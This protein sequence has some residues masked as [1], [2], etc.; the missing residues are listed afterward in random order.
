[1]AS[2]E[3]FLSSMH[4]FAEKAGISD[5]SKTPLKFLKPRI[6]DAFGFKTIIAAQSEKYTDFNLSE[7][8]P[9]QI[10]QY[11]RDGVG[12]SAVT[13]RFIND[14]G[15]KA[16]GYPIHYCGTVEEYDECLLRYGDQF[17]GWKAIDE[18]VVLPVDPLM[19]QV[20]ERDKS[21][22]AELSGLA[23][24]TKTVRLGGGFRMQLERVSFDPPG[25]SFDTTFLANDIGPRCANLQ[26]PYDMRVPRATILFDTEQTSDG[27]VKPVHV[28]TENDPKNAKDVAHEVMSRLFQLNGIPLSRLVNALMDYAPQEG[29]HALDGIYSY[30][31][32]ELV[33]LQII[34]IE[35]IDIMDIWKDK[36]P[37][38]EV[39]ARLNAARLAIMR[40]SV[41]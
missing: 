2:E 19:V 28:Q 17:I 24:G 25:F 18:R 26:F 30:K 12:K 20:I 1:M 21:D 11:V 35:G 13:M 38:N 9:E 33:N 29:M 40:D 10:H 27:L 7:S 6:L 31:N 22:E 39:L 3:R 8:T 15:R 5:A 41:R 32:G 23:Q 37:A 36:N 16:G 34:D 4:S 14:G